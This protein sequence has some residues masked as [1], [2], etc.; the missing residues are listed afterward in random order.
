MKGVAIHNSRHVNF[1]LKFI[2]F[3]LTTVAC[4]LV[5]TAW[6]ESFP[7]TVGSPNVYIFNSIALT[8]W[9][10][11][12]MGNIGLFLIALSSKSRWVQLA[13][14]FG[15]MLFVYSIKYFFAFFEG[16]DS[17]MFRV[18]T[19]DFVA[20]K[21]MIPAEHSYYEWPMLFTL[22]AVASAVLGIDPAFMP[23]VLFI[24]WTLALAG[25][26][27][28]YSER[29]G[30]E[31]DFLSVPI[32]VIAIFP[33]LNWQYGAQSYGLVLL[34]ICTNAMG[35][36]GIAWRILT[37]F[38]YAV[39]VASHAILPLFLI[40]AT[41]LIAINDRKFV[42][43]AVSFALLY[44]F[45]LVYRSLILLHD[46]GYFIRIALLLEYAGVAQ[47]TL[48][49]PVSSIDS[50][51][52]TISRGLTVSVW[53]VL[54]LLA[55]SAAVLRRI[56]AIDMSLGA[57]SGFYT[58]LGAVA[59][60]LGQRAIQILFL[61]AAHVLRAFRAYVR[62]RKILLAFFFI[63]LLIFPLAMIHIFYDDTNYITESE[64]H[65]ADIMVIP[66][67]EHGDKSDFTILARLMIRTYATSRATKPSQMIYLTV[68]AP[69][70]YLASGA[71]DHMVF[72]EPELEHELL[73][74]GLS[75]HDLRGLEESLLPFS[76]IYSDGRVT[77]SFNPNATSLPPL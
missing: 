70:G 31:R 72:M 73:K 53:G 34:V 11:L 8:F 43:P 26:L 59:P 38:V 63:G 2:G 33:F 69:P 51:G 19:Q 20:S 52:Q 37:F 76:R 71:W 12:S 48:T 45:N 57:S 49:S 17:T 67:S 39:L 44:G 36:N 50:I 61:P 28:L 75:N 30:D 60:I 54:M 27:F 35:R 62:F 74:R 10:G 24:V 58:V 29:L 3:F 41:I 16:A 21:I 25:G 7:V 18:L 15:F 32:Y 13:C 42:Y 14:A 68:G 4:I 56:R 5:A 23:G 47:Q 1:H 66:I 65:A 40:L 55:L 64:Q 46:L 77:I 6:V 22:G 9:I